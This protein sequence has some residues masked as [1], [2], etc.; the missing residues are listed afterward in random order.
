[1]RAAFLFFVTVLA[2]CQQA[3]EKPPTDDLATQMATRPPQASASPIA[4]PPAPGKTASPVSPRFQPPTLVPEAEKGEKGARNVLLS[5]AAA[6]EN[7]DFAAADALFGNGGGDTNDY[8]AL[9]EIAVGFGDGT[10]EGAAG[11]LYYQVPVRLTATGPQGAVRREGT[12]TLR[13]VNDVEGATPEQL[14]WHINT[15]DW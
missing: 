12:I 15:L 8:L 10:V 2:G 5:W 11:S 3:S 13:R 14:R 4:D 6:L 7:R 1:M 9:R